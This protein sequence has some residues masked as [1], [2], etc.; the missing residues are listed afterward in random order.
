MN[1]SLQVLDILT[2]SKEL[3]DFLRKVDAE[4]HSKQ[5]G[6]FSSCVDNVHKYIP[7]IREQL[8]VTYLQDT[9]FLFE[10]ILFY[11]CLNLYYINAKWMR[12]YFIRLAVSMML[13]CL[14]FH[15]V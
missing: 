12:G 9:I 3:M 11:L 14:F 2:S 8:R 7:S 13:K 1:V 5:S 4:Y 15:M 10:L 6:P